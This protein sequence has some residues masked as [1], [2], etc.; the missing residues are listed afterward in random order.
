[1]MAPYCEMAANFVTG[2]ICDG[3]IVKYA[4]KVY[5]NSVPNGLLVSLNIQFIHIS[6]VLINELSWSKKVVH[7]CRRLQRGAEYGDRT[8]LDWC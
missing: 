6:A 2:Q 4:R 8:L 1:M 3:P 7:L 5:Y